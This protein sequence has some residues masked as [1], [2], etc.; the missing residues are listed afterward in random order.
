[1]R[2]RR[3][4]AP[5]FAALISIYVCR[6]TVAGLTL[7]PATCSGRRLLRGDDRGDVDLDD[8]LRERQRADADQGVHRELDAAPGFADALA[9]GDAVAQVGDVGRD[10]DDVGERRA[11]MRQHALDLVVG[12]FAL[13]EEI[14]VVA[15]VAALAV[16][17]FG[18]D[19]GEIDELGVADVRHRHRLGED[20]LGP[21]AVIELVDLDLA[22]L[23]MGGGGEQRK[24]EQHGEA[25]QDGHGRSPGSVKEVMLQAT[26]GLA[27]GADH[28]G[29][30]RRAPCEDGA[31]LKLTRSPA[32]APPATFRVRG[33]ACREDSDGCIP[34]GTARGA[35][36]PGPAD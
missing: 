28:T 1:M 16:L 22:V 33:R 30:G 31:R 7:R 34:C 10:L 5:D 2:V 6:A 9:H 19:A 3:E 26:A 21:F 14:A 20:A 12:V 36:T 11:V 35:A 24:G 25:A 29:A 13:L 18:A 27:A 23:R 15:D 32:A 17:V 8:H 4:R